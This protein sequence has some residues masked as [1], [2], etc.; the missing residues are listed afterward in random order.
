MRW[1]VTLTLLA[2]G[3]SAAAQSSAAPSKPVPQTTVLTTTT[4]RITYLGLSRL[5]VG[6][7]TCSLTSK[8]A[9]LAQSFDVGENVT[10]SCLRN[11]LQTIKLAPITSGSTHSV[12]FTKSSGAPTTGAPTTTT[13]P[14]N[15]LSLSYTIGN[16]TLGGT[17]N[18]VANSGGQVAS[19]ASATGPITAISST[20]I[21]VGDATCQFGTGGGNSQ[22]LHQFPQLQVG[23]VAQIS[24]TM[25][26]NGAGAGRIV[27]PSQ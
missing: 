23:V 4:G 16:V 3:L 11:R 20:A 14:H 5:S 18:T 17:A 19:T 25:Y 27:V 26:A 7:T 6:R 2:G 22:F 9:A 13:G 10:V 24:C 12:T 21:S 15:L 1:L 8:S